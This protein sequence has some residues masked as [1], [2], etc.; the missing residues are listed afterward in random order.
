MGLRDHHSRYQQAPRLQTMARHGK[1]WPWWVCSALLFLLLSA[2]ACGTS[3]RPPTTPTPTPIPVTPVTQSF[4]VDHITLFGTLY[5]HGSTALILSNQVENVSSEW[6]DVPT[7]FAARGFAVLT[8]QYRDT[9]DDTTRLSDLQAAI[10]FMQQQGAQKIVLMGASIGGLVTAM[11]ATQTH[12]QAIVLL[13]APY[14]YN[15][16]LLN[17]TQAQQ[18]TSPALVVESDEDEFLPD[19]QKIYGWLPGPK[20]LKIYSNDGSHGVELFANHDD[21]FPYVWQFLQQHDATP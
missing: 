14:A 4:T 10:T 2:T 20:A 21:L 11:V 6:G 9:T 15:T 5:G 1:I 3:T 19:A 13:S 8:Y 16:I 12:V 7:R 17:V 18:I